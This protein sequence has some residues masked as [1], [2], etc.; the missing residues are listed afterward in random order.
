MFYRLHAFWQQS[1]C[2]KVIHSILYTKYLVH[3]CLLFLHI[4]VLTTAPES[5]MN[6]IWLHFSTQLPVGVHY[7]IFKDTLFS[8]IS[9]IILEDFYNWFSIS[10]THQWF[11]G[12][13]WYLS[14]VIH[15]EKLPDISL[16]VMDDSCCYI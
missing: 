8:L 5:H 7:I 4:G 11:C 1:I 12:R 15:N 16:K 13:Y 6:F 9:K 3:I 10:N 14:L 2:G